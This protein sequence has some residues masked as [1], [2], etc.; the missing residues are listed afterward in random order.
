M[1]P[2][3]TTEPNRDG[4][5]ITL[6]TL[7]ALESNWERAKELQ[8][9]VATGEGS[10]EVQNLAAVD[11]Q[12]DL[13]RLIQSKLP[14]DKYPFFVRWL[15]AH[16]SQWDIVLTLQDKIPETQIT[17]FFQILAAHA[18]Q[19]SV[20]EELLEHVPAGKA[21]QNLQMMAAYAGQWDLV[22]KIQQKVAP[23][24]AG[25]K[26]LQSMAAKANQWKLVKSI[27][28][29]LSPRPFDTMIIQLA[30]ANQ[31]ISFLEISNQSSDDSQKT[32]L[33][34]GVDIEEKAQKTTK[35]S[36]KIIKLGALNDIKPIKQY[37]WQI[38]H[39]DL[40]L[41][42]TKETFSVIVE[43]PDLLYIFIGCYRRHHIKSFEIISDINQQIYTHYHNHGVRH[44]LDLSWV[45]LKSLHEK[46]L[47]K[48]DAF[49]VPKVLLGDH[50]LY[51]DRRY[52]FNTQKLTCFWFSTNPNSFMPE[53]QQ[54][55]MEEKAEY[56]SKFGIKCILGYSSTLLDKQQQLAIRT[57]ADRF[58]ISLL[59]IDENISLDTNPLW[60]LVVDEITHIQHK[61]GGNPAALSDLCRMLPDLIPDGFYGDLDSPVKLELQ[62][63]FPPAVYGGI[64]ILF[65]MGSIVSNPI[66]PSYKRQEAVSINNDIIAY[67]GTPE[68]L[69]M[70]QTIGRYIVDGYETPGSRVDLSPLKAMGIKNAETLSVF[71]LRGL[72]T[73]ALEKGS[74]LKLLKLY[75][76]LVED[77]TGPGAIY[78]ALGGDST[79]T[80]IHRR[81]VMQPTTDARAL[82]FFAS[83][84][85]KS[86]IKSNNIPLWET[87]E[88]ELANMELNEEG[89]SWIPERI[90]V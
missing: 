13:V 81:N 34:V 17:D 36:N 24:L 39:L 30:F 37:V 70:R 83:S 14:T 35:I 79:F 59:D 44:L 38:S 43:H 52:Q 85:S 67:S 25:Q 63:E 11:H 45:T 57:F 22:E 18:D 74:N 61:T 68:D 3:S 50:Q 46:N 20:V 1:K 21:N 55:T 82:Q 51:S 73:E 64:P 47:V 80:K 49:E 54:K 4:N 8:K 86:V 2:F 41:K 12:W 9:E 89:L 23:T 62:G 76:S 26:Q 15:A 88:D 53:K 87:P 16:D 29:F 90:V 40:Y 77:I 75:K 28:I 84:D 42:I 33:S 71:E 5:I 60:Q 31:K 58:N 78:Q 65:N 56:L 6:Q 48:Q 7:A 27:Q 66:A 32:A 69:A 19:W 72:I 10:V